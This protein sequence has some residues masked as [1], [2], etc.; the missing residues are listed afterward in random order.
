MTE[1][2]GPAA[3]LRSVDITQKLATRICRQ[4]QNSADGQPWREAMKFLAKVDATDSGCWLWTGLL[5]PGGYGLYRI[6]SNVQLAHRV[7]YVNFVGS[8]PD[9]LTIDHLCQRRACVNPAHLEPVSR[10][11]NTERSWTA[12]RWRR[13]PTCPQGHLYDEANTYRNPKTGWRMC[14]ACLAAKARRRRLRNRTSA[15]SS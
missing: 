4:L 11:E 9:G 15:I 10:S 8:I 7:A 13:P 3:I 1:T 12:N 2:C 6:G 5:D 14:R